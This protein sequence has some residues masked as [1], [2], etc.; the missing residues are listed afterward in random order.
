MKIL[1]I[2]TAFPGD[3]I[4]TL[5]LIQKIKMKYEQSTLKVLCIPQTKILFEFSPYVDQAI[6]YDKKSNEKGFGGFVNIIGKVRNE[7]FDLIISPHRSTRSSLIAFLSGAKKTIS[8]DKSAA[9]FL[10]TE[11]KH[12]HSEWHEVKRNLSLIEKE[13]SEEDWKIY[14]E[15]IVNDERRIK[16]EK[17]LLN[18]KSK[19]LIAIAPGSVWNTKKYPIEF[20]KE[21]VKNLIEKNFEI[22]VI[23]GENDK[24]LGE[25]LE[26]IDNNKIDNFCGKIDFIESFY[27]L[28]NVKLL[29]S[30]DSAPTHLGVAADIPVLT[31]YCS[32]IP[33]FGFYPYNQRSQ[34]ISFNDLYCKPCGIHGF[35]KCPEDHFKCG[36]ELKPNLIIQ[37]VQEM[38]N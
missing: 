34:S 13:I 32:T 21:I 23:G 20:F 25:I 16:V 17:L 2:Q 22:A 19:Q 12:Y 35:E 11:L 10:Y 24:K 3:A 5:P 38:L 4:L 9:S 1:L 31:I 14:P 8:F 7:K 6:T 29:I 33:Q 36:Y 28:Q 30:N 18:L 15:L 27:L 26:E 37:K